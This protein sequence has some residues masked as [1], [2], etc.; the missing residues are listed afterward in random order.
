MPKDPFLGFDKQNRLLEAK[1]DWWI[2]W[3]TMSRSGPLGVVKWFSHWRKYTFFPNHAT[4][5]D[6]GCLREIA[7][8][9]DKQTELHRKGKRT[10]EGQ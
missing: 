7:N 8:F 6:P 1:T 2:V 3:P 5:L 10:F 9:C 4:V